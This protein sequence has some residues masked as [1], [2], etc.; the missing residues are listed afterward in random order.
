LKLDFLEW[1]GRA[2]K[3]RDEK[4]RNRFYVFLVCLFISVFI[5]ILIKLSAEFYTTLHYPIVYTSVPNNILLVN[6]TDS[7]VSLR[8]KSGGFNLF[9]L[10]YLKRKKPVFIDLGNIRLTKYD[11]VYRARIITSRHVKDLIR[12]LSITDEIVSVEPDTLYFD[13]EEIVSKKVPV[14]TNLELEVRKPYLLY[15]SLRTIPDSIVISGL[16]EEIMGINQ[17]FTEEKS[18]N[19]VNESQTVKLKLLYPESPG[20]MKFSDQEVEVRI[21]LEKFT[22]DVLELPV[23]VVSGNKYQLKI[24]PDK[25]SVTYMVALKDFKRVTPEMF[26]ATVSYPGN[27]NGDG[28]LDVKITNSPH[29]VKISRINPEKVEYIIL[30]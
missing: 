30:K 7:V 27:D 26:S 20:N 23:K 4:F 1:I 18:L 13:F 9:L 22:E 3:P 10:K 12:Q 25:V 17:V 21:S 16:R 2:A 29:F 8:M 6:N 11:G 5:W 28:K 24:Y 14:Y 15:D 19:D